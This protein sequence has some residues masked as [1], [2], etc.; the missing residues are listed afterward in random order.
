[1]TKTLFGPHHPPTPTPPKNAI[2]ATFLSNTIQFLAVLVFD[3]DDLITWCFECL[4]KVMPK[5]Q[6]SS[7]VSLSHNSQDEV[8]KVVVDDME[9]LEM[10]F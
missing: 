5:S 6:C 10:K 8:A 1:M 7:S 4:E 9:K 2:L 3:G